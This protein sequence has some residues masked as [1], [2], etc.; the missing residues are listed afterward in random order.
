MTD[1]PPGISESTH[2]LAV[3][4]RGLTKTYGTGDAAVKALRGIDI[5]VRRGELLMIVGPSGSGRTTLISIMAA[6][7]D[8]DYG[9]CEVTGRDLQHMDQTELAPTRRSAI[10]F[11]FHV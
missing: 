3:H 5:D 9:K 4:C 1:P 6:I 7:L 11:L 8:Q 10:R 2:D